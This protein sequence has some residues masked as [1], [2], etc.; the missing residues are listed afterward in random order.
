MVKKVAEKKSLLMS[1]ICI[2]SHVMLEYYCLDFQALKKF[3]SPKSFFW[4]TRLQNSERVDERN[5]ALQ[6]PFLILKLL[7]YYLEFL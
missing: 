6:P 3:G 7:S 1:K 4:K 2:A 5:V